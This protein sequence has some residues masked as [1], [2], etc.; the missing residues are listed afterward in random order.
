MANAVA[1][2]FDPRALARLG[3]DIAVIGGAKAA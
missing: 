1:A 3:A 2:G